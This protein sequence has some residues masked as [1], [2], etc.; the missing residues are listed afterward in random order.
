MSGL[1]T[2]FIWNT[3]YFH[4]AKDN[5][6]LSNFA[7]SGDH[8]NALVEYVGTRE[9]VALNFTDELKDKPAT[10]KQIKL[11]EELSRSVPNYK[12]T[13]EYEDYEKAPTVKN[14]SELISVLSEELIMH[15]E[16]NE[17][18]NLVEYAAKRPGVVKV[19]THGLFSFEENVDLKKAQEEIAGHKGNIWTH[20]LSLRREDAD[21]LGYDN[22]SSWKSLVKSELPLIAEAHNIKLSNL[23]WYG[24]MHNTGYHPH[25]HLFVF[26]ENPNEG[27]FSNKGKNN[28]FR[29]CKQA[30]ATKIF[31]GDLENEYVSKTEFREELKNSTKEILDKLTKNPLAEYSAETQ[32]A[33]VDKLTALSESLPQDKEVKYG[34]L[35][36]DLKELVNDIQK[37]II[38]ENNLL[39]QLYMKWCEHQ[40]NIERI[41]I[42]E[43]QQV[44]IE[45]NK[46]FT[47]IKNYIIKVAQ[48]F[49]SELV[50]ENADFTIDSNQ[51]FSTVGENI[52][53]TESSESIY[54]NTDF[55]ENDVLTNTKQLE[56]QTL[57][58][59]HSQKNSAERFNE[60]L[61]NST[62]EYRDGDICCKLADCY[63]YGNGTKKDIYQAMMWYGIS[64]DQYHNG[65]ASYRLAGIYENGDIED[66][67]K[68]LADRYYKQAY[69][70]LK[71]GIKNW[72]CFNDIESGKDVDFFYEKTSKNDAYKEFIIG[73]MYY[74]GKGVS[75]DYQ[76]A[77]N[78]FL[79]AKM[80]GN[81]SAEYYLG[82][83]AIEGIGVPKNKELGLEFL[84]NASN[85]GDSNAAFY[86]YTLFKKEAS[87]ES[88]NDKKSE[89]KAKSKQYLDV[90]T[91]N[92]HPIAQIKTAKQE[93]LSGNINKAI[94]LLN[95]VADD[96][97]ANA[98]YCLGEI[99]NNN[100]LTEYYNSEL[101]FE[102]F[103]KALN[104]Y[105][106]N[107][108]DEADGYIAYRIAKMYHY[109]LG[110]T[111]NIDEAV[112]WYHI[113]SKL[114]NAPA[115]YALY[116]YYRDNKEIVNHKEKAHSFLTL[117][118]ERGHPTAQ[119]RVAKLDYKHGNIKKA[120]EIF[121][122]VS[123]KDVADAYFNLGEIYGNPTLSDFYDSSLS[124]KNYN[125]ALKL[126]I[127]DFENDD[128]S[129]SF[130]EEA[131][132]HTAYNI[133]KIYQEGLGSEQ[134]LN[135]AIKW[136]HI[137]SDYQNATASYALYKYYKDN[138]AIPN[139]KE[140]ANEFLK[141]SSDR[142]YSMA[143]IQVAKLEYEQGDINTAINLFNKVAEKNIADGYY[144]LGEIFSNP[145]TPNY[146]SPES[147]HHNFAKAIKIYVE[148]FNT[149]P[150]GHIAYRIA[151]MHENGM[152]ISQNYDEAIKWHKAAAVHGNALSAYTLYKHYKH[153][154][155]LLSVHYLKTASE[156]NHPYAQI[157]VAKLEH[158]QGNV[159]KAVELLNKTTHK[160]IADT[161]YYLGKIHSN[162]DSG[163]YYNP[164]SAKNH[165]LKAFNLYMRDFNTN[166]N[167]RITYQIAKMYHYGYGVEQNSDEAI[168]W[169]TTASQYDGNNYD[170]EIE[171]AKEQ[172]PLPLGMVASTVLHIGR[173]FRNN[174][175]K[176]HK[177]RYTPDKKTLKQ[178]RERKHRAGQAQDDYDNYNYDY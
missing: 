22:Q 112:R 80:N 102:N 39:T 24:A 56:K 100:R 32:K 43:P 134:N 27:Y 28:S 86:L 174:T 139:H 148:D 124:K 55:D 94:E 171:S 153:S 84:T 163:R 60:L 25:I 116:K 64:A 7:L 17:A 71:F 91:K 16:F 89:C 146:Y 61:N 96:N 2:R 75:Q 125:T 67:D 54:T 164:E 135:E 92:E 42:K 121:D 156:L 47:P 126:Y 151:K 165:Y 105:I 122:L 49:K 176:S 161:F 132:G 149:E 167:G 15:G 147:A 38:Y 79:I 12:N 70:D 98:Y 106:S 103:S 57:Y 90:A 87:T 154:D 130:S 115:S 131:K 45:E 65:I 166:P 44:P 11:I 9:T 3:R 81:T 159:N 172:V 97:I 63:Y 78:S 18:A 160:E 5:E 66:K 74:D 82:R 62:P 117:S 143:Q 58:P 128:N 150:N 177:N 127:N 51:E 109:G 10:E 123:K 83:M 46:E 162:I 36:Q 4:I 111:E 88:S 173:V 30:F 34:Y 68:T 155:H 33:I 114:E 53:F 144:S 59:D 21:R 101:A 129:L 119:L 136:Y 40:F 113:S 77:I 168:K 104:I 1:H 95:N 140:I 120:V 138:E 14:A 29:K 99:Y 107:F 52:E 133:A 152:G 142:G 108:S 31:A 145:K 137:S 175:L 158:L 35:K 141:L 8:V 169:Y 110:T 37:N 48:N 50:I 85:N 69:Y 73:K 76:K 118:A 170:K 13:L 41:Y 20:V 19:G 6:E 93:Y 178:E 23:R 26:S 72:E 157:R